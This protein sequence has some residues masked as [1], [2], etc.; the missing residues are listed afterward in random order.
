[1]AVSETR[2]MKAMAK[3]A[4]EAAALMRSLS[5]SGRLKVLCELASGERSVGALIETSGLSQ[6]ALSQHLARLREEGVVA[7]RREAQTIY[8]SVADAKVLKVVRLLYE[9][10]CSS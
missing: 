9:L 6:S 3:K 10:Y 2:Q 1:M 8:Y 4:E 7:T 5:H